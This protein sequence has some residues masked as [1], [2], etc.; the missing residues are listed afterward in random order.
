LSARGDFD[1]GKFLHGSGIT[2][3]I[4]VGFGHTYPAYKRKILN[5]EPLLHEFFECPV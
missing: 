2:R 1:P 3:L 5:P 4:Y